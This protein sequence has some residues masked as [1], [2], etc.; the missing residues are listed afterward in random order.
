M[1][2]KKTLVKIGDFL[3]DR[4]IQTFGLLISI[5]SILLLISLLSYS[6]EDPNFIFPEN[7]EIQNILGFKGSIVAD[8]FF[9]IFRFNFNFNT[10]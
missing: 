3:I 6:P 4:F 2:I 5:I 7:T 9:S 8:F 1:E 10:C